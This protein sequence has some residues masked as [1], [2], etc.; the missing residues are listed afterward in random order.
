MMGFAVGK[1]HQLSCQM[2]VQSSH[3]LFKGVVWSAIGEWLAVL[4]SVNVCK[5]GMSCFVIT[6]IM[7]FH[8]VN[9]VHV[10]QFSLSVV[11]SCCSL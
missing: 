10:F 6:W 9:L 4:C 11:I 3:W 1:Y 2:A 5:L 7:I 8:A